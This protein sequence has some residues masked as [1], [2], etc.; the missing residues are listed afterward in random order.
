MVTSCEPDDDA[1]QGTPRA[2]VEGD[3]MEVEEEINSLGL[4]WP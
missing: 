4:E 2:T 3:S 1:E